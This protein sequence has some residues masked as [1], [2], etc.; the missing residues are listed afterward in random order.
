MLRRLASKKRPSDAILEDVRLDRLREA[1][2]VVTMA[3]AKP[4]DP[5]T[6]RRAEPAPAERRP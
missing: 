4:R 5:S 2:E 3:A 6:P 1:R